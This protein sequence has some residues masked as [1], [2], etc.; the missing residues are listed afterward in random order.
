MVK[1]HFVKVYGCRG[2]KLLCALNI[3]SRWKLSGQLQAA[4]PVPILQMYLTVGLD[5]VAN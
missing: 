4:Y 3:G 2:A 5:D 1:H